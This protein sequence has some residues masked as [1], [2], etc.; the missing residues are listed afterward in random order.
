MTPNNNYQ[1][2]II[3]KVEG[4]DLGRYRERVM[5][6]TEKLFKESKLSAEAYLQCIRAVVEEGKLVEFMESG[7]NDKLLKL[8]T[9]YPI[10]RR[11]KS[12]YLIDDYENF[13]KILSKLMNFGPEKAKTYLNLLHDANFYRSALELYN[14]QDAMENIPKV[15]E[16]IYKRGLEKGI[17]PEKIERVARDYLSNAGKDAFETVEVA[18]RLSENYHLWTII[19][20]SRVKESL[21]ERR[22]KIV[23]KF[24]EE[25]EK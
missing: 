10:H 12:G 24:F 5:E 17:S 1:R 9:I 22:K 18:K 16:I 25:L 11:N 2:E 13:A 7:V 19:D 3:S 15:I 6:E 20:Y 4:L 21:R 23:E 14:A 8:L